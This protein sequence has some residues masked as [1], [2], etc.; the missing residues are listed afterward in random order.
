MIDSRKV[1]RGEAQPYMTFPRSGLLPQFRPL[2]LF[3]CVDRA[4]PSA[5]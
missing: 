5:D 1:G 4:T 3:D 2:I